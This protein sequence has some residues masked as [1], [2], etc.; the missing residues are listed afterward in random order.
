[1][2]SIEWLIEE[3]ISKGFFKESVTLTNIDHLQYKAEELHKKEIT[4][5]YC[6]GEDNIDNDGCTIIRDNEETYYN[7]T[8]KKDL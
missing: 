5:A 8:F 3:M 1:M 7:E 6:A 4:D 2:T